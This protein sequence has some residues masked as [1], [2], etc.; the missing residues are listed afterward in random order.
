[1]RCA[2]RRLHGRR[3]SLGREAA[4]LT[5]DVYGSGI[6]DFGQNLTGA[7]PARSGALLKS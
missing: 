5:N 7:P 3:Q 1:L 6:D 2:T 4:G